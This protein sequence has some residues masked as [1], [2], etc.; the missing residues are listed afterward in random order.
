[1]V[2]ESPYAIRDTLEIAISDPEFYVAID[3]A[4]VSDITLENAP[5]ACDVRLQPE[6]EMPPELAESSMHCRR[7]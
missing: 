5:A 7:R 1:M 4:D 6:R 2:S 3:F